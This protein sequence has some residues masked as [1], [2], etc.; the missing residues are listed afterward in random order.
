MASFALSVAITAL[1][2]LLPVF[3]YTGVREKT[4]EYYEIKKISWLFAV[5]TFLVILAIK[6]LIAYLVPSSSPEPPNIVAMFFWRWIISMILDKIY[7]KDPERK[8]IKEMK[9]SIEKT[10]KSQNNSKIPND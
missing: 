8:A 6:I 2:Y 1:I 5:F 3:I 7:I 4:I 10:K 9:E